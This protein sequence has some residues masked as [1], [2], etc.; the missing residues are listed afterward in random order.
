MSKM[1]E[2]VFQELKKMHFQGSL[3]L[4]ARNRRGDTQIVYALCDP[5]DGAVRYVGTTNNLLGRLNE[6]MRMYGGNARKNAWLK[7]LKDAYLLPYVLTLEVAESEEE[8]REREIAWIDTYVKA[9]ADLL[10]DEAYKYQE[11]A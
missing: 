6:H 3:P 8:W 11:G 4:G 9:G 7:E 5:R 10:N 2:E 1:D